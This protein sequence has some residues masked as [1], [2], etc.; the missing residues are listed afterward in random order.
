MSLL[1]NRIAGMFRESAELYC[2]AMN[3]EDKILA[4]ALI[5]KWMDYNRRLLLIIKDS[6][7]V[8]EGRL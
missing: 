2:K 4:L 5:L 6:E 3:E 7:D 1:S 8:R